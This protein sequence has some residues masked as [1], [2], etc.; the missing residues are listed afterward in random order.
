M[1]DPDD[2]IERLLE[3][4]VDASAS[5]LFVTE[6]RPPS[7]RLDGSVHVTLHKPT[8]HETIARFL[9]RLLAPSQREHFERAGDLDVGWTHPTLGR[10]RVHVQRS[11]GLLG[12]VIRSVP[13]G[14]LSFEN[15]RLPPTLRALAE[16][17]RGLVLVT[18][19]TGSGKST[20]LA[21]MIHHIN[22]TA[23]KHIVTLEDP[24][25]F[26]HDDLLSIVTQREIGA[27]AR[28]FSQGLRNVL[29]QSPDVILIGEMRDA[30]TVSV[31]L[32][33]ALTG[34][35][36]LSSLHTI[37]ATQTLQR[38]SSYFPEH[39]REQVCMDL[40]LTLQGIVA[41]RLVPTA[42]GAGRVPAVEVVLATPAVRRLI[43]EQRVDE[44]P[45]VMTGVEGMQSF[46]R[47]LVDL[48]ARGVITF[49]TGSA[50]ASNPDEFRLE[51]QGMQRGS[52]IAP[53]EHSLAPLGPGALDMREILRIAL[54][55]GASD[56]HL[57]SDAP[58]TLRVHGEL[59]PLSDVEPLTPNVVRRLL[60]SL[61]SHGQRELYDL[62]KELDFALSVTGGHR[63]RVNAHQQ[64]GTAAVSIR[65]I[66]NSVPPLESLG[67][68]LIVRDLA[69][70]NQGLVLVTGPTGSGKSTTLAAMIDLI[71]H[72]RCCHV[73]T[74]ED[75]IEFVHRNDLALIEQREIGEDSKSFAAALKYIL[76]Q[77]PDVILIGEMR[78][79]E[80][81][82]AALT[83]AETG[84]LVLATLHANDAPAT[85]DRIVDVFPPYQQ[86]Q[87]R[88]QLASELLAVLS[89]RLV[90]R[91]DGQGRLG[92]FEVMVGTPAVR[93]LI[94]ENKLHQL[95]SVMET[96][97]RD[98][99]ITMDRALLDLVK[100]GA[101]SLDE[102]MR[103]LRNP[104][105]LRHLTTT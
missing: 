56:V 38:I 84:H 95:A 15:L 58:P 18:G 40:S 65:L 63:F 24:I 32:S 17:P 4:M 45:D 50:Y 59:R 97:A 83:A 102:A 20:T 88:T 52:A 13:S 68:P 25:E 57:V 94:R 3:A 104:N 31:A 44:I 41:Q 70:R 73:I 96:S 89:Q 14:Q 91:A 21:A 64:R 66:P 47:A 99:M 51:A 55:R 48:F 36:V 92:V 1:T 12:L 10:F 71:N 60:F 69:T 27:D 90:R 5:D 8:A 33:A 19:A 77:D 62:E 28:D 101:V 53:H 2:S 37:D 34:H 6:G 75:P 16:S 76:R 82:A 100:R 86:S 98:G 72:R 93:T 74:I 30:E 80:T 43:R 81:I 54:E 61:L 79:P 23:S 49:E 35:L 11:R 103:Y 29:R 67:L 78:D 7:W 105:N 39:M 9:S 46:N 85:V 26:V 87:I 42:D 22:T